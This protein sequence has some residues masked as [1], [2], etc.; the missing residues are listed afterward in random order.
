[1]IVDSGLDD[2]DLHVQANFGGRKGALGGEVGRS[3]VGAGYWV[4]K[5]RIVVFCA[6][7]LYNL[8]RSICSNLNKGL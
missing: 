3:I 8:F 1:L 5:L 6:D 7:V 2:E 4:V